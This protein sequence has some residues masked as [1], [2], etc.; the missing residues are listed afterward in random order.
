MKKIMFALGMFCFGAALGQEIP[1]LAPPT[2]EAA[3]L[4]RYDEVPVGHYRGVPNINVPIAQLKTKGI[5]IPISLSYHAGG[6][7][8]S[9]VAPRVGLGWNISTG[10]MISRQVRGIPDDYADGYINTN[11]KVDDYFAQSQTNRI[12]LFEAATISGTQDYESDVYSFNF[13]GTSGKFYFAQNGASNDIIIHQKGDLRIQPL[14]DGNGI[15]EGWEI[16]TANGMQYSFGIMSN[17]TDL[18]VERKTQQSY[19]VGQALPPFNNASM[20]NFISSWHLTQIKDT[21]GNVVDYTYT[22]NSADSQ[23]VTYWDVVSHSREFVNGLSNGCPVIDSES[24]ILTQNTYTPVFLSKIE[25]DNGRIEFDYGLARQDLINDFAL[26]SVKTFNSANTLISE[27]EFSY[28]YFMSADPGV[29]YGQPMITAQRDRR[30]YLTA[31]EEVM[32]NQVNKIHTFDYYTDHILG[33]L[34]LLQRSGQR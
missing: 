3:S 31:V 18:A 1:N 11:N 22:I 17:T 4:E 27:Y 20:F 7:R 6:I 12:Q 33:F 16:T 9:E 25:G 8:V 26:T 10:G 34:G 30:L 19:A 32:A 29:N 21:N 15:I 5:Q 24:L 13:M 23:K 28:D 14:Q 2:P